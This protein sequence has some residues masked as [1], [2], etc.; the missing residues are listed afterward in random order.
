MLNISENSIN[1]KVDHKRFQSLKK[2]AGKKSGNVLLRLMTIFLVTFMV[3]MFLPWTQIVSSAGTVTT[4]RPDQR[5]QTI[6]SVIPG[7]IEKWFVQEG[8][9]VQKGDTILFL[10]EVKDSY[11][12]PN[13]LERTN[14]QIKSKEL[15]VSSY[16]DK[17]KALDDQ[18]DGLALNSQL[19]Q[20]QALN[21]LA[22][23]ELQVASD[24]I[25]L[26]AAEIKHQ[27][28]VNQYKRFQELH[29]S[30]LKSLTELEN[31]ELKMQDAL[32]KKISVENKLL[33]SKNKVINAR[34]KLNTIKSKYRNEIAK[35]ESNKYAAMSSMYDAEAVVTKMQ[36]Q[37]ANYSIRS[38]MYFIVAPQDGYLTKIIQSGIGETLKE[39]D[40]IITIMPANYDLVV[41]M[42]VDPIDL[43]LIG[44]GQKVRIQFEGWPAIVFS[45]WPNASYGTY[46]GIVYAV[47]NYISTNGKYR[48]LVAPDEEDQTWPEALRVGS[49]TSNML[50]LND[51]P[52]WYELWRKVNNFPPDY[53]NPENTTSSKS[54]K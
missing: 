11:F 3:I 2:M 4:M 43:P 25:D 46:G 32:A 26:M 1:A 49:A 34:I 48:V 37:Y 54:K 9:F 10:T 41:E 51:V 24:S 14:D 21:L 42:Y 27:T 30:G 16:M 47:D 44:K 18:I 20:E 35:A 19:E 36:N 13:L 15:A 45:G 8:D 29:K 23:S 53:N 28:A 40:E 22:Q 38:G 5:P 31:R 33:T 52:I 7:R 12:D 39:G 50:L 17:V 6:N